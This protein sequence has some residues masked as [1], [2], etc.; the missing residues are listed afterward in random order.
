MYGEESLWFSIEITVGNP[1]SDEGDGN[2]P[3]FEL[4][5]TLCAITLILFYK[6]KKRV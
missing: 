1:K 3:G 6:R 2:T 4:I 5:L